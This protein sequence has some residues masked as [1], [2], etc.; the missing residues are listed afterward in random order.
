MP[1][2]RCPPC[3]DEQGTTYKVVGA[4]LGGASGFYGGPHGHGGS[5]AGSRPQVWGLGPQYLHRM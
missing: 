3:P 5:R 4:T 1:D 2:A